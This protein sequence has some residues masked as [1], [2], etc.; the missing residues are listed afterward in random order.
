MS[1]CDRASEGEEGAVISH[2]LIRHLMQ[3]RKT[4]NARAVWQPQHMAI[5]FI[6]RSP[7]TA[8]KVLS[9]TGNSKSSK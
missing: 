6:K 1:L 2:F 3:H 9:T 7:G 8:N 5:A 4:I